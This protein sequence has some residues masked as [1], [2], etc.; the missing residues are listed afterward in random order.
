M[1]GR[2][3]KKEGNKRG[4][5]RSGRKTAPRTNV[6]KVFQLY[7]QRRLRPSWTTIFSNAIAAKAIHPVIAGRKFQRFSWPRISWPVVVLV[8]LA[9]GTR[10]GET[11]RSRIDR[12][13]S[14]SSPSIR[15]HASRVKRGRE[16]RKK[17]KK[18]EESRGEVLFAGR[19]RR[20]T[21]AKGDRVGLGRERRWPIKPFPSSTP[22]AFLCPIYEA[23]FRPSA[24][25]V[26][27]VCVFVVRPSVT[28]L[29][30]NVSAKGKPSVNGWG[31]KN[32]GFLL[33]SC[34]GPFFSVGQKRRLIRKL[35]GEENGRFERK[36]SQ[37]QF[38]SDRGH[39]RSTDPFSFD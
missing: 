4:K 6:R 16:S 27:F 26:V 2:D 11:L 9:S 3:T 8:D 28:K 20:I 22:P 14:P 25:P 21:G 36:T 37:R 33:A 30:A 10:R 5:K 32:R 38:P 39:S 31:R 15:V 29:D 1:I 35:A 24:R 17:K 7:N 13:A 19:R 23:K 12:C 34:T 18:G